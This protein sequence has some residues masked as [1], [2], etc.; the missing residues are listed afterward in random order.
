MY[1]HFIYVQAIVMNGSSVS[2][3]SPQSN[4]GPSFQVELG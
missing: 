1:L 4:S 2:E 3:Q